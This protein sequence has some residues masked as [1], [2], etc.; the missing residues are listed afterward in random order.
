[1]CQMHLCIL[2]QAKDDRSVSYVFLSSLAL[3]SASET[4]VRFFHVPSKDSFHKL[5]LLSPCET[6]KIFPITDQLT[7]H[8][9]CSNFRLCALRN[10]PF[11]SSVQIA[12]VLSSDADAIVE[13]GKP[14]EGAQATSRTQSPWELSFLSKIFC[15]SQLPRLS[16]KLRP[17]V[18]APW[19]D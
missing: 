12:T 17:Y 19:T 14:T 3:P 8:T 5:T 7:R 9:L 18:S 16:S 13:L 10:V 11:G 2:H 6:A 15:S 4:E 1:M